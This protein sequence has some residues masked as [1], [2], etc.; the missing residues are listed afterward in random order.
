M[1]AMP[2]LVFALFRRFLSRS[3]ALALTLVFVAIPVGALFGSTYFQYVKWAARGFADPA[4]A[5]FFIGGLVWLIGRTAG[6]PDRR[7]APAVAA[8]LLF[9]L[10]LWVRP[11]LAPGAAILLGG[12]GL[13]ALWHG[14]FRRV[15]GLCLGFLPVFGMALHNW[16]FGGG[17]F[18]LFSSNATVAQALPMPPSA[19]VAA[20]Y[21][22]L[23]GDMTGEHV[24]GFALQWARWLS[25]PSESF[26][27]IPFHVV[28]IVILVRVAVWGRHC[29][30]WLRLTAAA[31]LALH[32]VAWFYLSS[33]RY[34]ML[35]WF[36]TLL[37][38]AVWMRDE[39]FAMLRR[40]MPRLAAALEAPS[41]GG[42]ARAL[43]RL[44]GLA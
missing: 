28:A 22:L 8:G 23:H 36:L 34:Y 26:A 43:D 24:R 31:A 32:P 42:L 3:G 44:A 9:A 38:C 5:V 27:M 15:A 4:A 18:V 19:Y 20:L 13:A 16:Y 25:G 37:V 35:T 7:F 40:R 11:N 30:P 2:F 33:G 10:A 17:V 21:E 29:D 12:A 41:R 14:Q 1:L 6:G 39:G